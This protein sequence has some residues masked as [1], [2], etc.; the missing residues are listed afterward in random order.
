MSRVATDCNG[1]KYI[2]NEPLL[3]PPKREWVGLTDDERDHFTYIDARDK[4]RFRKHSDY[5]E[6]TLKEKNT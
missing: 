4:A 2:T 1:R 6:A 3:H 5:I